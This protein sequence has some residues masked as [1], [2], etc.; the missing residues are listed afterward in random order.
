MPGSRDV[1]KRPKIAKILY[2]ALNVIKVNDPWAYLL[3]SRGGKLL[4]LFDEQ[5]KVTK[6]DS[7]FFTTI[8]EA[9]KA[10]GVNTITLKLEEGQQTDVNA[11]LREVRKNTGIHS[12]HDFGDA[13]GGDL[14]LALD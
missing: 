1:K 6:P 5:G 9:A 11:A 4:R 13:T 12:W 3:I 14:I 2:H 7:E 8:M 10:N